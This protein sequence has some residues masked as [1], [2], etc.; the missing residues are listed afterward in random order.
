MLHVAIDDFCEIVKVLDKTQAEKAIA[1][2]WFH[3]LK[4]PDV[5]MTSGALARL[6]CDHHVGNP[7]S[8][9]LAAAIRK[10]KLASENGRGFRLKPGSRRLIRNWFP[11]ALDG[12]QPAMDHATGYL[13]KTIWVDTR[14]YI[15]AVCQQL[16]GCYKNAYYDAAAVMLRRLLETLIIEAYESNQRSSEITDANGDYLMLRGLVER[17]CGE[18]GNAG[19]SLGRDAKSALKQARDIGNWSAHARRYNAILQDLTNIQI[20]VRL[21]TQ[22]LIHIANL[23]RRNA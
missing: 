1:L 12:F 10:T 15:E 22:E 17:A 8:T 20:G 3:D 7:H 9:Q 4:Q 16:N 14:G 23:K 21:A 11:E 13:P 2:L 18:R 5:E 6:I 19:L